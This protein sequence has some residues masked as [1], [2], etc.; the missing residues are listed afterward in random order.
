MCNDLISNI[1]LSLGCIQPLNVIQITKLKFMNTQ[2]LWID[3]I[4]NEE[5]KKNWQKHTLGLNWEKRTNCES[6]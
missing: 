2:M 1:F 4:N 5:S 3:D 6:F